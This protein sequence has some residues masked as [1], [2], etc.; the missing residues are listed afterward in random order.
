MSF[1]RFKALLEGLKCCLLDNDCL[2]CPYSRFGGKQCR[3]KLYAD[4]EITMIAMRKG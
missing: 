3:K 4:A 1:I 2:G